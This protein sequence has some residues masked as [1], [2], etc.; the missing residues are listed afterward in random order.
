MLLKMS[1]NNFY[2]SSNHTN[3]EYEFYDE[4]DDL[5][6]EGDA[7]Q[8]E[9]DEDTE[10]ASETELRKSDSY[11]EVPDVKDQI[12]Q[13]K[14]R[15]FRYQL[16][17]LHEGTYPEYLRRLKR[18][19]QQFKERIQLNKSWREHLIELTEK[20]YISE[21]RSAAKEFDERSIELKENLIQ[22]MDEKKKI[23]ES[24]RVSMELSGDS[25][26]AKP[27]MT[28]K[29]RRRPN[30]PAPIP[31]KRRGKLTSLPSQISYLLDEKEIESDLK[32]ISRGI[33][34]GVSVRKP[35]NGLQALGPIIPDPPT[36]EIRIEDGKL[37]YEKK[38]FH[39]GQT[40]FVEGK[41][42]PKFPAII[43]AIG[44]EAISVKKTIDSSKVKIYMN[45]LVRGKII[46]K[47][48]AS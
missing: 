19:E 10:E 38:W 41:D 45:Q 4:N 7:E 46:I 13:E 26:E 9:S 34:S 28:R 20:D 47:R 27:A 14:H 29:L 17:Q 30:D 48:R 3:D 5:D 8:D 39:R 24:E 25:T 40:V 22:D 21:K 16:Q 1:Y 31:E 33:K 2:A 36:S 35:A 18:L 11:R 44:S 6:E 43:S 12:Y 23:V 15:L 42:M 32:A 37:L